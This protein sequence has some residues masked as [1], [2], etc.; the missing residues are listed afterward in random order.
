MKM[1]RRMNAGFTLI[2][3]MVVLAII[4]ILATFMV[5]KI[6]DRPDQARVVKAKQDMLQLDQALKMYR[7]DNGF[8]PSAE[9]GLVSL[10]L[11]PESEPLPMS[12]KPGGYIEGTE[13]PKD[14]WGRDY[15]YRNPGENGVDFEIISLGADGV[16]G[17]EAYNADINS[18]IR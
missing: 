7:L 6:I 10:I 17:G 14:P 16:E 1:K 13:S 15:I 9:Q 11:P 5:P 2:E 3:I 8:Y 4:G 12:W 18:A